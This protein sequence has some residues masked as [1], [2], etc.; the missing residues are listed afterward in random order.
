MMEINKIWTEQE[1]NSGKTIVR[2]KLPEPK[3]LSCYIGF[4][5]FTESRI[6]EL[7]MDSKIE[8]HPNYLSKFKGVEIQA[9]PAMDNSCIKYTI[10]LN[11]KSLTDIFVLFIEDIIKEI[12]DITTPEDA[13]LIINQR[14]TYW[15]KLFGK[16]T[17]EVLSK[18]RQ[19]GLYGELLILKLLLDNKE[20]K[21]IVLK[22][23]VGPN[24]SN[25]DF[26]LNE[27]AVEVKTSKAGNPS[28]FI[29]NEFQLDYCNWKNLFL[30]VISLN[31]SVGS[32]DS[33]YHL[34]I[35]IQ[36]TL[37]NYDL[38]SDFEEK[39][40]L[41]GVD[42]KAMELYDEIGYYV[43]SIK[44]YR[45]ED[46]FP[47]I[48]KGTLQHEALFNVKY[49]IDITQCNSFEKSEDQFLKGLI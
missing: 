46:G 49:Q 39:L 10:I 48:L 35:N 19:R 14:V 8:I 15:K 9:I 30:A 20:N 34:I 31:E 33:L 1:L 28:V 27:N 36:D 22:S 4:I 5:G 29:S 42:I 41:A 7:D 17:G 24:S 47:V 26:T 40:E 3:N 21:D 32:N 37:L 2:E 43:K 12:K 13:L 18:E 44:Y 23:W 25:Q 6:F 11:D 16:I 38:I 45:V